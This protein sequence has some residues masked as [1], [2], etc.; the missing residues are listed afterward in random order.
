MIS[1]NVIDEK[2]SGSYGDKSFSVDFN[3]ELYAKMQELAEKANEA[4]SMEAYKAILDTFEPLA[5]QDYTKTIQD[6]CEHIHVNKSTGEF[7]LAYGSVVS[8]IPMPQALVDR[9]YESMDKELD[10][11]PLVKMWTRWL[12]NPVLRTKMKKGWGNE[13]CERFF[14][15][16]NLK[17]VH[18]K[19]KR[20]NAYWCST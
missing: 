10:F 2:I 8:S 18:P 6:K 20:S 9:I 3:K 1:I 11:M 19:L 15:Y 7:F 14:N 5:Q 13:F 17:Y 16:I 12:R 4:Q